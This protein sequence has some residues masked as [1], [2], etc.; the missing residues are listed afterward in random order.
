MESVPNDALTDLTKLDA[1]RPADPLDEM[2]AKLLKHFIP[3]LFTLEEDV[4]TAKSTAMALVR[5][6][7][8]DTLMSANGSNSWKDMERVI[9]TVKEMRASA[10]SSSTSLVVV[11]VPSL[12]GGGAVAKSPAVPVSNALFGGTGY[13]SNESTPVPPIQDADGDARMG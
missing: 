1:S 5:V 12:F 2:N 8:I 13:T 11:P 4:K 3:K 6:I 9:E 10:S 7:L